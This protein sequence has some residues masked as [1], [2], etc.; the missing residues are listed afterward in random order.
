MQNKCLG[1]RED[2][3]ICHSGELPFLKG[4]VNNDIAAQEKASG[5]RSIPEGKI[6]SSRKGECNP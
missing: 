1:F 3:A 2:K 5:L 4:Y 6:L